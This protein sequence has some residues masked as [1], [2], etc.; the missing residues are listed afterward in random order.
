MDPLRPT[1]EHV[2]SGSC[3]LL[4]WCRGAQADRAADRHPGRRPTEH[5]AAPDELIVEEPMTIQLD[6]IVVSTTMRTPGNDYELAAGFC[7]TEGLLAGAP[8]T[9]R[10]LLRRR[11]GCGQPSSTSSPS[12]PAGARPR[13]TPRLGT[14]SSS[15]GWC[16]SDQ[17][18]ELLDRLAPLPPTPPF[19]AVGAGRGARL[20]SSTARGCSRSTG[21]VHAAAAFDRDGTDHPHP[22][23]RRPPQRRRQGRRRAAARRAACRRP[24]AA[25][26]SAAGRRSR[27]CRRRGRPGSPP[28]VAVSAPTA[29]A[30]AGRPPAGLTLAGFV[31]RR[32]LQRVLRCAG[33]V[34]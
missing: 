3:S 25:C 10:A 1:A 6:G 32:R 20:A 15:C 2:P 33:P 31:A 7:L 27:W 13:P 17:I 4:G 30:V 9:R 23:G 28:L 5:D 22:R 8:V 19:D 34:A 11:L 29:L 16:G 26:S 18:D 24:G 14:T 12:R 21:A